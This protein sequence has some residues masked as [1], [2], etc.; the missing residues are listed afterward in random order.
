MNLYLLTFVTHNSR[1]SERM[2]RLGILGGTPLILNPSVRATVSSALARAAVEHSIPLLALNVLPDHAHVVASIPSPLDVA[3][4]AQILKGRSSFV[5]RRSEMLSKQSHL[6]AQKFH[7]WPLRS[8]TEVLDAVRYVLYNHLHHVEHWG[9]DL[10]RTWESKI[11]PIVE[12]VCID[13]E[14]LCARG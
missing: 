1:I 7:R 2:I 10:E 5:V 6:W 14:E 4:V 9:S 12:E 13:L 11:R 3:L 8:E